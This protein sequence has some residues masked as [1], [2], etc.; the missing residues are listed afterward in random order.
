MALGPGKYSPPLS[1]AVQIRTQAAW[2][3]L[4]HASSPDLPL[5]EWVWVEVDY[6]CI[7]TYLQSTQSSDAVMSDVHLMATTKLSF[8]SFVHQIHQVSVFW[9]VFPKE[10][11][12]KR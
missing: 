7:T 2:I 10:K 12:P 4:T 3:W 5:L 6:V 11:S 8:D 1:K 9:I